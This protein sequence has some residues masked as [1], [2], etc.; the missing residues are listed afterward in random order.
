MVRS[1][2]VQRWSW[3]DERRVLALGHVILADRVVPLTL[4]G[5]VQRDRV[6]VIV[7]ELGACLQHAL[8][9]VE[10][11]VHIVDVSAAVHPAVV[12]LL[13][14][15][16]IH[17]VDGV[18]EVRDQVEVVVDRVDR[19]I[20]APPVLA[21]P[22]VERKAVAVRIA[23]GGLVDAAEA[24]D[25]AVVDGA[26]RDLVGTVPAA[27]VAHRG[28]RP[29]AP[30]I[31]LTVFHYATGLLKVLRPVPRAIALRP[32]EPEQQ[33]ATATSGEAVPSTR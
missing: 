5:Q 32:V 27:V 8:E 2:D 17:R 15:V 33:C 7:A 26:L 3:L 18:G 31:P 10:G 14:L 16:A 6:D 24:V 25:R 30:V 29:A 13:E 1:Q 4:P 19:G 12:V 11:G 20:P 9:A 21:R 23:A 28:Q 22:Q